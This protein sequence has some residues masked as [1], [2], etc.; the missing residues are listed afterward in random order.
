[1][2]DVKKKY[3]LSAQDI[4]Y[5]ITLEESGIEVEPAEPGQN[6]SGVAKGNNA[7]SVLDNPDTRQEFINQLLE[8]I[9]T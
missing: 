6:D 7:L 8:V 5:E 4:N 9:D 2:C 1:M 3:V